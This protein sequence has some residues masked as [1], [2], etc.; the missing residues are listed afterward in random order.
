MA[1]TCHNTPGM[2]GETLADATSWGERVCRLRPDLF[3]MAMTRLAQLEAE[4]RAER[5]AKI[6]GAA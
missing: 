2:S 6:G 1:G 3:E 4:E 5:Q